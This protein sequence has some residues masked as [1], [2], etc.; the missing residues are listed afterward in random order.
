MLLFL[1]KNKEIYTFLKKKYYLH[2]PA[3]KVEG[4][5]HKKAI[6]EQKKKNRSK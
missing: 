3:E 2:L 4:R 5:T 6:F 1:L